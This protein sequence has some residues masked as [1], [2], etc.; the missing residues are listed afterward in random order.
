MFPKVMAQHL[1]F[2]VPLDLKPYFLTQNPHMKVV[3]EPML[4]DLLPRSG[5]WT[6]EAKILLAKAW[7]GV[8]KRSKNVFG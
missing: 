2:L 5:S 8:G 6:H 1:M 7:R 3:Y 4:R